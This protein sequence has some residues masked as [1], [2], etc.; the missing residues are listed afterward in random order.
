M[1]KC[2]DGHVKIEAGQILDP[3]NFPLAK[4]LVCVQ[5]PKVFDQVAL[6]ECKTRSVVLLTTCTQPLPTVNFEGASGFTITEI[7]VLSRT[8]VPSKPCFSK[9]KLSVKVDYTINY[10]VN[11]VPHT[12]AD[13]VTFILT[14]N[15]IYCPDSVAQVATTGLNGTDTVNESG[16]FTKV[17][18]LIEAF[19]DV[20]TV[21]VEGCTHTF[22]LSLDIGAFFIVKCEAI[23]QLLLPAYGYCPIPPE[24]PNLSAQTCAIFDN[25]TLTPFPTSFFPQQRVNPL[26]RKNDNWDD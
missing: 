14:V 13:T 10:S 16:S 2:D 4:E 23:V 1:L 5:V 6:R 7:K 17:E 3:N 18:A 9:L 15:E 21:S 25:K 12:Q 20:I 26:D 11:D 8:D 22:T 24:Q 19:H